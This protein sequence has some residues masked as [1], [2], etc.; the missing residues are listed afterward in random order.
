MF[1]RSLFVLCTFSFGHCV[2]CSSSIYGFR[3]LLLYLQTP[4]RNIP[5]DLFKL[6]NVIYFWRVSHNPNVL[7]KEI[8]IIRLVYFSPDKS[9]PDILCIFWLRIVVIFIIS[10]Y[11]DPTDKTK[12]TNMFIVIHVN[13]SIMTQRWNG[14]H[15]DLNLV[16]CFSPPSLKIK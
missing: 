4:F 9:F 12:Q 1:C 3:L 14:Q 5:F 10:L 6:S 2:V 11:C 8:Y 13:F 15:Y 7:D 16:L